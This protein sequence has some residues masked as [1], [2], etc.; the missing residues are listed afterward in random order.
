MPVTAYFSLRALMRGTFVAA[1]LLLPL[2]CAVLAAPAAASLPSVS[3][4][5]PMLDDTAV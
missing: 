1:L 3:G 2:S 4:R 5:I